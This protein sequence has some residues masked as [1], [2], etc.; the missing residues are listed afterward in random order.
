MHLKGVISLKKNSKLLDLFFFG[1]KC[2]FLEVTSFRCILSLSYDHFFE[3]FIKLQFFYTHKVIKSFLRENFL[4]LFKWPWSNFFLTKTSPKQKLP[5]LKIL[6]NAFS[7]LVLDFQ[8]E[9]IFGRA[10][11]RFKKVPIIS[12]A[13]LDF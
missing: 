9:S 5:V 2:S 12:S 6:K 4:D 8:P 13:G 11:C 1:G 10:R 3:I 7:I